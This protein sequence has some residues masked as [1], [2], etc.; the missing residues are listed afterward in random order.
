M[1]IVTTSDGINIH[2]ELTGDSSKPVLLF[3][4]SLGNNKSMWDEQEKAFANVFQILRYDTRGHGESDAPKGAYVLER[5]GQDVVELINGLKL[6]TVHFC[7]LS[8][9]GMTGMWLGM[10]AADRLESLTLCCTAA[11]LSPEDLWNARIEQVISMGMG[12]ITETVLGRWFTPSFLKKD[13]SM[14]SS[15]RHQLLTT[16]ADGYAGC[17]AAIKYMDFRDGLATIDKP[18]LVI[19]G[20]EDKATPPEHGKQIAAG[21]AGSKYKE[22]PDAAHLSNIEQAEIFNQYVMEFLIQFTD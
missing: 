5:L 6:K 8:L 12:S 2:Y 9:G 21:I 18:C 11:H 1:Q 13:S 3:S 4:N 19:S 15:V 20:R 10:N 16:S 14:V 22:I 7:G 17:C